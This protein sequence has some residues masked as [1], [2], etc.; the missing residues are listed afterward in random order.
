LP[1]FINKISELFIKLDIINIKLDFAVSPF[2]KIEG[3]YEFQFSIDEKNFNIN[4]DYYNDK[5]QTPMV[6]PPP[7]CYTTSQ[8]C[9]G[10]LVLNFSVIVFS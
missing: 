3:E 6:I 7:T 1:I 10:Q 4:I 8:S 2:C 5:V 9:D